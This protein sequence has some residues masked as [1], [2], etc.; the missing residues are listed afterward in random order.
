M[1]ASEFLPAQRTSTEE[2]RCLGEVLARC[3]RSMTGRELADRGGRYRLVDRTLLMKEILRL[4]E[5][6]VDD[7][8]RQA[9][10]QLGNLVERREEDARED[11][12]MRVLV[13]LAELGDL[14]DSIVTSLADKQGTAE[15]R[16]LDRRLDR[17]FR[18]YGFDRIKTVG[19]RFDSAL[20]E[21]IDERPMDGEPAGTVIE[22]LS[23][24]YKKRDFVL[25]I[26]RVIVSS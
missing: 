25:R 17:V 22:E 15:A 12:R 1:N 4:V 26:A 20:H 7:R 21:A 3:G 19:E 9:E 2:V 8:V 11:G 14:V 16:A 18:S 10:T 24:G 5:V 23:R 6:F 13:S